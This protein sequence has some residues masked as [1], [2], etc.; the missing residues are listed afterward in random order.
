MEPPP[1]SQSTAFPYKSALSASLYS[2]CGL[3]EQEEFHCQERGQLAYEKNS[4]PARHKIYNVE[5]RSCQD[6][7]PLATGPKTELPGII[8]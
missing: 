5:T 6:Q 7:N 2:A 8:F 4:N 1:F 3:L